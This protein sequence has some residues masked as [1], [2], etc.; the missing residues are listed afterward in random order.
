M[1]LTWKKRQRARP[2]RE[3][4]EQAN[5]TE[6]ED[7]FERALEL[8]P[9]ALTFESDDDGVGR[10]AL[11][12]RCWANTPI[13]AQ[14]G[15]SLNAANPELAGVIRSIINNTYRALDAE[16]Y[17]QR[18]FFR[19]EGVL[20]NLLRMQSQKQFPLLTA[21]L[22][23]A[24]YRAQLPDKMWHL[25][26]EF[27][28]GIL[29]SFHWTHEF[30]NFAVTFRPPCSYEELSM[31]GATMFDNYSR[32]VL[33]KSQATNDSAGYQLNMTNW[34]TMTVPKFMAPANF[35]AHANCDLHLCNRHA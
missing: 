15:S 20:S 2:R 6:L 1:P 13:M 31:V 19:V 7:F 5:E 28:P 32:K 3:E 10:I 30:I 34:A 12:R 25:I 16:K 11:A 18:Q 27:A 17:E 35:D 24:A 26:H 22:S 33:Y 9:S 29:A 14:A 4:N 21:R 23:I 8:Q